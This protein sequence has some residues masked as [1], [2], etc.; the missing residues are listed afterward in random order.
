MGKRVVVIASGETE[1]RSLPHLLAHLRAEDIFVVEIRIPNR[2]KALDVEMAERI[3]KSAWYA[4]TQNVAPDKFV[5]LVD[6]DGNT[7][8]QALLPFRDELRG[9]LGSAITATLQF[10]CAQWHLEAWYFADAM[11]L[12]AYIER[13][14]G[15]V[16]TSRPDE[17]Q[18]PKEHLKHLLGDRVYTAV[19]SEEIA[20][21]LNAQTIAQR[22]PSFRGLIE[23]VRNGNFAATGAT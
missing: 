16:D 21:Q 13:D 5:I 1:R 8:E 11:G 19:I 14:T 12:R 9:R 20:R 2:N 4:P 3:V 17:I 23:A 18:N 6:T 7:P 10:A 15:H 22:S